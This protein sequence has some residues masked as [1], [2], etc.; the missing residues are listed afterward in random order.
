MRIFYGDP[1]DGRG[2]EKWEKTKQ[3]VKAM[4]TLDLEELLFHVQE[5]GNQ[6]KKLEESIGIVESIQK[7]ILGG[8]ETENPGQAI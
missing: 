5:S 8:T 4:R 7:K 2:K 1:G 6:L 3:W